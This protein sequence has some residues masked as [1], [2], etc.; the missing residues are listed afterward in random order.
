[1]GLGSL[2]VGDAGAPPDC[3][4]EAGLAVCAEECTGG[5]T[6]IST[7]AA[8]SSE[9]FLTQVMASFPSFK[10]CASGCG[11]GPQLCF[12]CPP[13]LD[14]IDSETLNLKCDPI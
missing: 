6:N 3:I 12:E 14:A 13:S 10:D 11:L 9:I 7:A 2:L 8:E 1:M 4:G 5:L